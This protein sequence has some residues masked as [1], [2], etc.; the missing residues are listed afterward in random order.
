VRQEICVVV[1]FVCQLRK[2]NFVVFVL[3]LEHNEIS[4]TPHAFIFMNKYGCIEKIS[5][6]LIKKIYYRD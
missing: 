2:I 6:P 1:Y 5:V 3:C 4:C